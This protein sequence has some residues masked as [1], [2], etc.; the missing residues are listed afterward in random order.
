MGLNCLGLL[1]VLFQDTK[2]ITKCFTQ[3][4]GLLISIDTNSAYFWIQ[5]VLSEMLSVTHYTSQPH[6]W[7][8]DTKAQSR[9]SPSSTVHSSF[10][11]PASWGPWFSQPGLL[12]NFTLAHYKHTIIPP[13]LV[14]GVNRGMLKVETETKAPFT[15]HIQGVN[16]VALLRIII[17]KELFG[18]GD[19]KKGQLV[20]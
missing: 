13:H 2:S 6:S 19:S 20:L 18:E 7:H 10:H 8:S 16:T 14:S 3:T 4:K 5:M 1:T 12:P 9:V 17:C 15:Q 11:L